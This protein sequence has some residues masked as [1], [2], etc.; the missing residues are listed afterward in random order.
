MPAQV[1]S[2]TE[3]AK[4]DELHEK[5]SHPR[6]RTKAL[7]LILHDEGLSD[8]KIQRITGIRSKNTVRTYI[9]EYKRGGVNAIE[10]LN[11]RQA[12]SALVPFES[13]IRAYFKDN[14]P[15]TIN[16]ICHDIHA[17]TGVLLQKQP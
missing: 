5:H 3:R 1:L 14:M 13:Q 12:K 7:V 8:K 17:L 11:F 10:T 16:Q 6:I 4:L 15:S 9:T 2:N